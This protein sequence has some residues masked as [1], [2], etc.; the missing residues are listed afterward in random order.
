M[1]IGKP[2]TSGPGPRPET[3]AWQ[4]EKSRI[5]R[6]LILEATVR[7]LVKAG[8]GETL[9]SAIAREAGISRGAMTHH[10]KS[11]ADVFRAAAEF[12]V[13]Q[14]AAEFEQLVPRVHLARGRLPDLNSF[15]ET[16]H[17]LQGFYRS[18]FFIAHVE[19][20]RGSR[21]DSSLTKVLRIL[22]KDLDRS[23][24]ESLRVHLPYWAGME[25]VRDRLTDLVTTAL[26]GS[27]ITLVH[28]KDR[29]RTARLSELLAEIAYR[30]FSETYAATHGGKAAR[31]PGRATRS[32]RA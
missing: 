11:R 24:A 2:K 14:R 13:E 17:L 20:L 10:F 9:T 16:M 31:A 8:Y 12:I 18:P 6:R 27:A 25:E 23:A 30:E 32:G 1:R 3:G 7:C 26:Q 21:G 5:T 22:Q 19:L 15:R 4:A 28:F 29:P